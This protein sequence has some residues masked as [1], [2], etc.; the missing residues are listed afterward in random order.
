MVLKL[1][2]KVARSKLESTSKILTVQLDP[3]QILERQLLEQMGFVLDGIEYGLKVEKLKQI[4]HDDRMHLSQDVLL[5]EMKFEQDIDAVVD[6]EK[7]VHAA[8]SSSRINF[9]T[10]KAIK[11]MKEYYRKS[12]ATHDVFVLVHTCWPF[13]VEILRV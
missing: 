2:R 10:Q 13:D 5:R 1:G 11:G 7:C 4:F 9:E 6:L 12:S 3:E 8:G